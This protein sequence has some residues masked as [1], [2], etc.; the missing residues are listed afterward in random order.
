MDRDRVLKKSLCNKSRVRVTEFLCCCLYCYFVIKM[1]FVLPMM[2]MMVFAV[3]ELL[4]KQ[5][6]ERP[7]IILVSLFDDVAA[8]PL[9]VLKCI[10]VSYCCCL[11]Y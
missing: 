8:L 1:K 2:P 6:V 3:V 5:F 9:H 7:M 11:L 10:V 4:L